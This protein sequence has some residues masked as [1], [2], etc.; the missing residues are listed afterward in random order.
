MSTDARARCRFYTA[1]SL[2]GFLATDDDSLQWLFEQEHD[3]DGAGGEDV[4]MDGVSAL[5]MGASTYQWVVDHLAASGEPWPYE[6]PT[7][8]FTHR[9]IELVADSVH[10][11]S[12]EP[13]DIW[14]RIAEAAGDGLVWMV[15]GGQ[16]AADFARAGLLDEVLVSI[17]S[18]TLG[19]GKP[20]F[21]GSFDLTLRD[22]ERNG[23]FIVAR[24]D[25]LG[26]RV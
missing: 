3:P 19:S 26:E 2:D 11:V 24:Y 1:T 17:A 18:V 21:G 16:L 25:V 4:A 22:V 8:V 23:A 10:R 6:A 14:P 5:V 15:G 12:G 9:D 7:F 13:A 20:L